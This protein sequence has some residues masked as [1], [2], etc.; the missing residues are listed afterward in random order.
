MQTSKNSDGGEVSEE[1]VSTPIIEKPRDIG[2]FRDLPSCH[3]RDVK[4]MYLT[5][6]W[7]P[8]RNY[9]FPLKTE[10]GKRRSFKYEW[11]AQFPWLSY[12]PSLDG[13]FVYLVFCL[14]VKPRGVVKN[15]QGSCTSPWTHGLQLVGS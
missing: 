14:A 5:E 6:V 3:L 2:L 7:K 11:L 8:T 9:H 12:S 15:W 13:A 10:F 4:Y 1:Q